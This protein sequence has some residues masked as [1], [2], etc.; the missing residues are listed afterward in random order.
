MDGDNQRKATR[1][2]DGATTWAVYLSL[3]MMFVSV[4]VVIL[5][6]VSLHR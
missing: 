5:V 1:C 2:Q 6:L 3:A 4:L